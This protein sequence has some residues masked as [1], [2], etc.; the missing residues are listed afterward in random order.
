MDA[1]IHFS[2]EEFRLDLPIWCAYVAWNF[3]D[4]SQSKDFFLFEP[5]IDING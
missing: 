4:Y 1:L 2:M 3:F 5:A